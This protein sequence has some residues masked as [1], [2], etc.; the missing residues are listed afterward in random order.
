MKDINKLFDELEQGLKEFRAQ[1][2]IFSLNIDGYHKSRNLDC[3]QV[4]LW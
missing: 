2:E 1:I 3:E 4:E